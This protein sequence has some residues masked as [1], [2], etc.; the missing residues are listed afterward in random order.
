METQKTDAVAATDTQIAVVENPFDAIAKDA[1][2]GGAFK[3]DVKAIDKN[4][5]LLVPAVLATGNRVGPV[6]YVAA[7][8]GI[9]VSKTTTLKDLRAKWDKDVI[10]KALAQRNEAIGLRYVHSRRIASLAVSDP[11]YRISARAAHSKKK[12][13]VGFNISARHIEPDVAKKMSKDA[14]IAA[15]TA[16]LVEAGIAV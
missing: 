14:T 12:G 5:K 8:L 16:R 15:L 9:E 1:T 10:K 3:T 11:N 2:Y 4:G 13:F 6:S 7:V